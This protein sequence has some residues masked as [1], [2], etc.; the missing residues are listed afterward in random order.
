MAEAG[1]EDFSSLVESRVF[2]PA[3]MVRSARIHRGLALPA[4]PAA[5]LAPPHRLDAAGAPTRA[6]AP[7]PQ[8]D[9]TAGGVVSTVLDLARFDVALD[10]GRLVSAASRERMLTPARSSL[11]GEALPY[12]LGMFVQEHEGERL[13]WHSGWWPEAYS[14]LYLKVPERR[15]T[16]IV[17]ANGE[18][19]WWENRL[20]AAEVE[21]SP[22]ARAFLEAF[23]GRGGG[24]K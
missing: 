22:F 14:A 10:E 9:G 13:A 1:G 2:R 5:A 17:L 18:G 19:Q 3:G 20:D 24:R 7:P 4:E 23:A 11:T 15:L 12:G 21:R 6:P 16:L 8:G